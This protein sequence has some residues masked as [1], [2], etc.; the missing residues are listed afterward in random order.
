MTD[1]GD[2]GGFDWRAL[3]KRLKWGD[4]RSFLW[5][6]LAVAIFVVL[7]V[8]LIS[9]TSATS[10]SARENNLV[11]FIFLAIGV[12]VSF[13]CGRQSARAAAAD[14]L[15]PA[16]KGAVRRLANLAAG[17]GSLGGTLNAQRLYMEERAEENS[18][19]VSLAEVAQAQ[20][21]LE[22]QIKTQINTVV[23]AIEDWREF[24]PDEIA[25]VEH[26]G[27]RGD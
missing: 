25:A 7:Y 18:G 15:R 4:V 12:L 2:R 20:E 24:I 26:G 17:L 14:I 13:I 19:S 5:V 21:M 16:A 1:S 27:N 9:E 8:V 22:I 3:A 11:Q 6:V 23:D 10:N